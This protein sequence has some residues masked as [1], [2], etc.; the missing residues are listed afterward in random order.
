MVGGNF[1]A[2]FVIADV[3][4]RSGEE[5]NVAENARISELVLV[6]KVASLAPFEVDYCDAVVTRL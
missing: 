1:G 2:N 6:F 5:V 4:S 3:T